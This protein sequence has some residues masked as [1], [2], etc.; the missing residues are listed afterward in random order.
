MKLKSCLRRDREEALQIGGAGH[1]LRLLLTLAG[2]QEPRAA[3]RA[4]WAADRQMISSKISM[5]L[6]R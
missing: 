6:A 2:L 5:L 4:M 1:G 3:G